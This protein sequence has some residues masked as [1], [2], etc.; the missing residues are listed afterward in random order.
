MRA[1]NFTL[2]FLIAASPCFSQM[3]STAT[4]PDTSL[5]SHYF[6][7]AKTLAARAR[8]DS[9]TIYYEK[10]NQIYEQ[11]TAHSADSALWQTY[12]TSL[13]NIGINHYRKGNYQQ[14]LEQL[15][16][17]LTLGLK[18]FGARHVAVVDISSHLGIVHFYLG[19][20]ARSLD[21]HHQ[22]LEKRLEFFGSDHPQVADSY[23]N[24][25]M[26]FGRKNDYQQS[27]S[28]FKK[29]LAIFLKSFG[30]NHTLV[31]CA[32]HNLGTTYQK[33][34]DYERALES[35][36]KS[37][38]IDLK[39]SGEN[40]PD[41]GMTY[42][43]MGAI[44]G[45][46]GDYDQ[47]FEYY[48]KALSIYL[49]AFGENHPQVAGLYNDMGATYHK[50]GE[51]QRALDCFQKVIAIRLRTLG[52]H[53]PTL[54][55]GYGN[56][57]VIYRELGNYD[58]ALEHHRKALA[59]H[60]ESL[61]ENHTFAA[62]T[63]RNIGVVHSLKGNDADALSYYGQSLAIL[64][65]IFG[66]KHPKVAD[67]YQLLG[68]HYLKRADF[69]QALRNGQQAIIAL[70]PD[71]SDT[72]IYRNPPLD[73][74]RLEYQTIATLKVKADAL[75]QCYSPNSLS[76]NDLVMSFD[77]YQLICNL[78]DKVRTS[79]HAEA[80]KLFLEQKTA[81][82]Y[83]SA[84]QVALTLYTITQNRSYHEAAFSFA[85]QAKAGV[86]FSDL[87]ESN[88]RHF[89]GIP[90]S[91]LEVER[92]LKIVLAQY[93]T[94]LEKELQKSENQDSLLIKELQAKRFRDHAQYQALIKQFEIDYPR[95]FDL[96]Y[97]MQR[98]S[99]A[100]VQQALAQNSVLIEYVV[101]EDAI[102]IFTIT[103][104]D[105][106]VVTVPNDTNLIRSVES[107]FR[108]LKKVDL[109]GYLNSSHQVYR[110]LIAPIEKRLNNKSRMIIIPDG[111]LYRIPFEALLA[112]EPDGKAEL[113]CLNYLLNQ[114]EISYHYSAALYDAARPKAFHRSINKSFIGFAPVF[115]E[116]RTNGLILA[117]HPLTHQLAAAEDIVRAISLDGIRIQELSHSEQEVSGIIEQFKRHG[118]AA[119]G[120]FHAEA[121][122]EN[123]KKLS[124]SY[125]VV[126]IATHGILN[127]EHPKL[128]G[129]IFSPPQDSIY[130]EDGVL[131]A[132]E[133]YNLNL[134]ADLLVLSSCESGMGKLIK[135]EG[136]MAL[137]RGF[138]Y[139]GTSNIVVSLWKVSDKHTCQLM[140]DFYNN[141]LAGQ[142]CAGALRQAKLNM[143]KNEATA[144]PKSW[145]GFVLVGY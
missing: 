138:L 63:Y 140:I 87:Q 32:Y 15:Q 105:F 7:Q 17:A 50:Q 24:L 61:P 60:L 126:H 73:A 130:A 129:L 33:M 1:C 70:T 22:V 40:N 95:Y 47:G 38:A 23:N 64:K 42:A 2:I 5:A 26:I 31:A 133:T 11:L 41:V 144:F 83:E 6:R 103:H 67:I 34:C 116:Q 90:D 18:K 19:N 135:G 98:P 86:L 137:T 14:S 65:K 118:R 99:V 74:L 28:Y 94:Q 59:I 21:L 80:S 113:T 20:Y 119:I 132:G 68:E 109:T 76:L 30:E 82:I 125:Q 8:F 54:A 91:L 81:K 142:S 89:V 75:R 107:L 131:Y 10:A 112:T 72:S 9:S 3:D 115:S 124:G 36:H 55:I 136:I 52:E 44:Y 128:A 51:L 53:H 122:E 12:L 120:Y 71:F 66:K 45:L 43:R 114:F 141:L 139:S 104:D 62:N 127:D 85:E 117:S 48:H 106:D 78:I 123:F 56:L 49:T 16:K 27:L 57:G 92:Q 101:G 134:K 97:Q 58:Q 79:Y 88:A 121:S 143:I 29:A 4:V 145:G 69:S 39:L 25:A 110:R 46:I 35:Y 108:S 102:F 77:T 13:T 93:E 111:L 84:I 100:Q 96:K 37:L